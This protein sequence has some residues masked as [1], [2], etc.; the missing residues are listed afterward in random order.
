MDFTRDRQLQL[1]VATKRPKTHKCEPH[2]SLAEIILQKGNWWV[3][4]ADGSHTQRDAV[5]MNEPRDTYELQ[6]DDV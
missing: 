6:W 2:Q 3:E 1:N 4:G 5:R